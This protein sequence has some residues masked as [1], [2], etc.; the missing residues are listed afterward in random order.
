[1]ITLF[2]KEQPLARHKSGSEDGTKE[3]SSLPT[4]RPGLM[5]SWPCWGTGKLQVF[6]WAASAAGCMDVGS[7]GE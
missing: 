1:M 3:A 2:T 4:P 7:D 5:H 6:L